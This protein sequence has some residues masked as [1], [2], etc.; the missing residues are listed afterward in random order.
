V[1]LIK[2]ILALSGQ[3]VRRRGLTI[4]VDGIEMGIAR[5]R[6]GCGRSLPDWQGCDT[7][8][9]FLMNHD[10]PASLDG[11]YFGIVPVSSMIG[12]AALVWM[13]QAR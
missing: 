3:T 13:V 4:I 8:D 12:R 9:V 6:D 11:R 5:E 10:E 2:R 1:P 7:D